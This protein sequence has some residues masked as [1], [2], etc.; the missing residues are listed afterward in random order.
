MSSRIT[1]RTSSTT[2]TSIR[3]RLASDPPYSS[4]RLLTSGSRNSESR[5]P[6]AAWISIASNPAVIAR[7]AASRKRCTI[8]W[9]SSTLNARGACR[10]PNGRSE[11]PTVRQPPL[12]AGTV[13]P[14]YPIAKQPVEPLRPAWLSWIAG[15]A[16]ACLMP[17]CEAAGRAF[18]S[19]V[20][21]LD[22]GHGAG[23]FDAVGD[24]PVRVDLPVF[25]QTQVARRDAPVRRDRGRFDDDEAEPAHRTG[26]IVVGDPPVRVDLPVFPQTQVA[27][28]D[29]PVRRDRGRFDDDEAEPAHRT[30]DI[31][32]VV[33]VGGPAV[34]RER[35]IHVHRR[36][37]YAGACGHATQRDRGEQRR[38]RCRGRWLHRFGFL[39][40]LG[41]LGM[42]LCLANTP[43]PY[44]TAYGVGGAPAWMRRH[45]N[46]CW[47]GS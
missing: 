6:C 32:L 23:L 44:H 15:T 21:E 12:S 47:Q 17:S 42:W 31:V 5:Y 24:P 3:V 9:I 34:A 10:S 8:P 14:S 11:G 2:S 19:G 36:Q 30:G 41:V 45:L 1:P 37:P 22:R 26:D 33:E 20:V 43:P 25:P 18:A 7:H 16:P 13:C 27:R 39:G 35:R 4:S 40:F 46:H 29:A 28:R 38:L